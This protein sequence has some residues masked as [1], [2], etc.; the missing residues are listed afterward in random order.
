MLQTLVTQLGAATVVLVCSYAVFAGSWRERF[1]AIIYLTA[2]LIFLGFGHASHL[3]P[4][5]YMIISDTL[6][7]LGFFMASWK[8]PHPWPK[9]AIAGQLVSVFL[10]IITLIG[11]LPRWIFLTLESVAGYGVLMS[12]L[13]G[14]IAYRARRR[15]DRQPAR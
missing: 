12:L 10:G 6:C 13:I 1:G 3:S 7:L 8:S 15:T 14:T 2:Y 11:V 9:W 4:A 5:M